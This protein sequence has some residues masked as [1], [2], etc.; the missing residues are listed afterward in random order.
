VQVVEGECHEGKA[1]RH[2][3]PADA[4]TVLE[5]LAR[6]GNTELKLNVEIKGR[7]GH[8][9]K[10][11]PWLEGLEAVARAVGWRAELGPDGIVRVAPR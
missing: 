4:R 7:I 3:V 1:G 9:L 8:N 10:D 11:V 5:G 2:A 6:A